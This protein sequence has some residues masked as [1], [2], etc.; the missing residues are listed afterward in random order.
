MTSIIDTSAAFDADLGESHMGVA[1]LANISNI[2][3]P[4]PL[5][6]IVPI[7]WVEYVIDTEAT[8]EIT[9]FL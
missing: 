4:F 1:V 8:H 5:K 3:F 6:T 7:F 9:R 2:Q